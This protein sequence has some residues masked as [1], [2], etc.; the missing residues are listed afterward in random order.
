MSMI[1][2]AYEKE[3]SFPATDQHPDA[4]RYVISGGGKFTCADVINGPPMQ[5]EV[6]AF[7]G[8]DAAGLAKQQRFATDNAERDACAFDSAIMALVNQ[9]KAEWIAWA[10]TNFPTLTGPERNKLGQLFWVVAIGVRRSIR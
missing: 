10:G 5:A 8:L 2:A 1:R 6:D 9:T 7:L 4:V 3:P